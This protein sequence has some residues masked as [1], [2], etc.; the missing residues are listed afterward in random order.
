MSRGGIPISSTP[1]GYKTELT[2]R[3]VDGPVPEQ[4]FD[5]LAVIDALGPLYYQEARPR[6]AAR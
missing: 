4:A 6:V 3:Y 2:I 5:A 1:Q